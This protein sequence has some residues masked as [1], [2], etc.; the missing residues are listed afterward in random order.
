MDVC[1]IELHRSAKQVQ[2]GSTKREEQN[3]FLPAD[4]GRHQLCS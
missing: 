2:E 4:Y 3:P 1:G